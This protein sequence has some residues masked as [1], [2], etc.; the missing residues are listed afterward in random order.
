[1]PSHALH[2]LLSGLVDYA[3]L[4]PPARL[5]M[6]AAVNNYA[7]YLRSPEVWALGRF[8]VPAARL[9]EFGHAYADLPSPARQWRLSVLVD[10]VAAARPR[11]AAPRPPGS[12]QPLIDA[13]EVKAAAP[14]AIRAAMDALPPGITAYFELPLGDGLDELVAALAAT[15]GRAK[16]RTGGVTADAFP[17][18]DGLLAFI[19]CCVEHGVPFKATAGLHH[20][21][22]AEYR[23]T[24]EPD[25]PRG[26][27]YGFL[28]VFLAAAA[29]H[30][31]EDAAAA[32]RLLVESD[33]ASLAWDDAGVEWGGLRLDAAALG[34][35]R[36]GCAIAFGS[37]SFTEPIEDLRAL[38]WL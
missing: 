5:D 19:R 18:P 24:Y 20:P 36:S 10:D 22:R 34:A 14:E 31:G 30:A 6:P 28:N 9:G 37:C 3:G 1:M 32:G 16:V 21:L 27:M 29:L 23:L 11:L 12:T 38:G 35:A 13:V 2:T 33:P 17:A 7:S 25:S 15:G 8:I 26:T 4:F